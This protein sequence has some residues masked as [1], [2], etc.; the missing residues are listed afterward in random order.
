MDFVEARVKVFRFGLFEA[1]VAQNTLTRS[2]VRVKIQDQPLRVLILLLQRPGEI[3]TR[4]ELRQGLWPEGTN[5]DFDGSLNVILKKLR[6]ALDD[7]SDNPRFIETVPRRGYRF[8]APVS[9]HRQFEPSVAESRVTTGFQVA[10]TPREEF[11]APGKAVSSATGVMARIHRPIFRY[12][13]SGAVFLLL[14]SAGWLFW[15]HK[16]GVAPRAAVPVRVRKS[17]AVLGFHS[18]SGRASDAWLATALSEMLSTELSGGERLRLVSGEDVANLRIASPWSQTNT[19]DQGTTARVGNALSS[20]ML[21]LGSYTIIG[22]PEHGQIRIDV[23]M[24]DA[25]TGEVL[26]EF[27]ETGNTQ[28][29]FRLVSRMGTKLRDRLGVPPLE[30]T[31]AAGVLASLPLNPESARLYALG[32]ARLRQFDALGAKDLLLQATQAEPKFS[33]GHAM[34]ARAWS[35][36]GYEQ[37]HREE[38]KTA[39]DLASD[40]PPSEHMLVEGEYYE[41]VGN[42][43]QA[44]SVYHALYQLFPDNIDYGLR[45]AGAAMMSGNA[46]QALEIIHQLRDLPAPASSDPRIDLAE[47][48]A[49][50]VNKPESLTLIRK[51]VIKALAQGKTPLYAL[52][53]REECMVLLWG[54]HPQEAEPVC[55][56]AYTVFLANGNRAGAADAVRLIA[57]H[58]GYEGHYELAIGTYQRA[59]SLLDGLGEHAKTGSAMNNMAINYANEGKLDRALQLYQKAKGHFEQCGDKNNT[60]TAI[61]NI[62]DI[63]YLRGNLSQAEKTYRQS[64]DLLS[65]IDHAEPGYELSRL[66]DLELAEGRPKEA[67][68]HAQQA[69]ESLRP[70]QGTFQYLTGAMIELGDVFEAE[71]D[72]SGARAQFEQALAIREKTGEAMLVAESQVELAALS[73]EEG[74]PDSAEALL[75]TALAEFEKEKGEP[76]SAGAEIELSRALLLQG[77]TVEARTALDGALQLSNAMSNP[78]VKL[79]STIQKARLEVAGDRPNSA[80]L[81]ATQQELRA[82]ITTAEK[83]GYYTLQT[84]AR[85]VLGRAQLKTNSSAGR[86]LLNAVASE[87]HG[88]GLAL[89]A[90]HA[91]EA[92]A[93]GTK[94]VAENQPSQ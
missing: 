86:S 53:R 23:R 21:V 41:S 34:L 49:I 57:D 50:K 93:A 6:A 25:S 15:R 78:A 55:E 71:G 74:R 2:G 42:Q 92:L 26:T 35:Q 31:D 66:A 32:L 27:A 10:G 29:L 28:D 30:D 38:A 88:R 44:A 5:V 16:P 67:K 43:A 91:Q 75:R 8:I 3:V 58:H 94:A 9:N 22:N 61:T 48:R 47:S 83:L 56:D 33:L 82:T 4:E 36:L 52:A 39:L 85:L 84:E 17:V 24:Q 87:A 72:L 65:A 64:L 63:L 12:A 19:L 90:H 60:A 51:A 79:A 7:D 13:L 40:L 76:D 81:L 54:D 46:G 14:I 45:F 11:Q 62:A 80:A 37:K 69:I 18:L 77:K 59:L 73:M 1:D 20:D 68:L 70:S 89:L